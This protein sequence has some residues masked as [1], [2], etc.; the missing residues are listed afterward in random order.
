SFYYYFRFIKVMYLGDRVADNKPL[1]LSPALQTALVVS[2]IGILIVGVY[3]HYL[4]WLV[5][6]L[7][8]PLASAAAIALK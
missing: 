6:D 2:V 4:I 5:Q 3:P 7:I 1:A 8:G